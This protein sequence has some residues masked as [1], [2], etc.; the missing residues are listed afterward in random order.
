MGGFRSTTG[1][2]IMTELPSPV[3]PT[4]DAGAPARVY[5]MLGRNG[6]GE[7]RANIGS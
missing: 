6:S 4:K 5:V 1:A 2:A 3:N 7:R